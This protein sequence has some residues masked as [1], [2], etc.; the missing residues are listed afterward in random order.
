MQ[1]YFLAWWYK[2]ISWTFKTKC[3]ICKIGFSLLIDKF[4]IAGFRVSLTGVTVPL[5][6]KT[7]FLKVYI[8]LFYILN[9]EIE[10]G[11]WTSFT[12]LCYTRQP[13]N[14]TLYL[15]MMECHS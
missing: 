11:T 2:P 10:I 1:L 12:C 6:Q 9:C 14:F 8:W 5:D 4:R 7:A 3:Q 13:F 15:R